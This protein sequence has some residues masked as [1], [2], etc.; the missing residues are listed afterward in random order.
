M[1]E[2]G[3]FAYAYDASLGRRFAEAITELLEWSMAR[4]P[5]RDTT[6]F[7]LACGT[8]LTLGWFRSK[9]FRS[10]G[11]DGSMAMLELARK[12]GSVVALDFRA[13]ALRGRFSRITC[14]YDS[15]NHLLHRGDL[16]ET[17]TEVRRLM[18]EES[19]FLFDMNHPN[20]YRTVWAT[21]DPFISKGKS[22]YLSMTTSYS[23]FTHLGSAKITGWAMIGGKR[24]AIDEA[25]Q[26]RSYR[27]TEIIA[28]LRAAGL[29]PVEAIRFDPFHPDGLLAGGD[30]K[31]FFVA[32]RA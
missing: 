24:V 13:L 4:H 23:S 27:Q 19:L 30:V 18:D 5:T 14:L 16:V 12:H 11:G 15:L 2:Y 6:H 26:Q 32:R 9:G 10:F 8:G 22:H 1:D 31:Y 21:K 25:H 7:D 29:E 20:A 28:A 3:N 17:F